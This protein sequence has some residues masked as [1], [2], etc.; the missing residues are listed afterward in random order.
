MLRAGEGRRNHHSP[1]PEEPT[2]ALAAVGVS[3]GEAALACCF[4]RAILRD[5]SLRS[6]PQDEVG[7][8]ADDSIYAASPVAI[9]SPASFTSSICA[10]ATRLP[11][12]T[13]RPVAMK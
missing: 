12:R 1:H 5:A 7:G 6:A 13:T 11:S 10:T 8:Y 4:A 3:K 2:A 9:S